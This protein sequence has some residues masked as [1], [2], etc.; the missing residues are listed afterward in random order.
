MVTSARKQPAL[1]LAA[2]VAAAGL[3]VGCYAAR[4]NTPGQM[5][6]DTTILAQVKA[7]MIDDE[8]VKA[9]DV[10]VEVKKGVVTLLGWVDNDEEKR[11]AEQIARSV[12]GVVEVDNRLRLKTNV[13][14]NDTEHSP[15]GSK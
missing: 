1:V 13:G 12:N 2:L 14:A 10:N 8:R 3:T 7:K 11:A 6:D 15:P 9:R 5:I 4:N